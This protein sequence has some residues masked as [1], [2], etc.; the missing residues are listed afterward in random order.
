MPRVVLGFDYGARRIGVAVGQLITGTATPLTT[1]S[2]LADGCDWA[3]IAALIQTWQPDAL[4]VGMPGADHEGARAI[5][6]AIAT[7]HRELEARFRLPVYTVDEAY[8]SVEA[9]ARLK[10]SRRARAKSKA[11]DR[12]E[13]DRMAAAILLEAWMSSHVERA[14]SLDERSGH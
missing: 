11:I 10:T 2:G 1:L 4:V 14:G 5:R 6:A 13:I 12:S 8:T 9:Y 7:F 3:S